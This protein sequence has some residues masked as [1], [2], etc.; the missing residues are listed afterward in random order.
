MHPLRIG[1]V[2]VGNISGIYLKNLSAT[3]ETEVVACADLDLDRAQTVATEYGVPNVLSVDALLAHPD[4]DLVLNLTIPKVHGEVA[5]RA[6]AAGK[7]VY[8][9]KPLA[10]EFAVAKELVDAARSAGLLVGCAPDTFL[11]SGIQT[12][13]KA[14]DDGLIGAPLAAQAFMMGFG[15]EGW[16]PNPTFFYKP[17][18]GPMLDMGPYYITALVTLLGP[19]RR[20][21]G[22][23][24][25]SYATRTIG[26]G[27]QKGELITVETPTH[28]SGVMEMASGAVAAITTSFD[29]RHTKGLQPITIYGTEGTMLVPDPNNFSG[30]VL[31]R[32]TED[33]EW[34]VVPL[35][36]DYQE[37][38]RGVGIR[39]LALSRE[40]GRA[41]RASGDLALHVLETMLSFERASTEGRHIEIET[42]I[43]RPLAL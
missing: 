41:P 30:E 26:S 1:V 28:L 15:P 13:R 8:N 22:V 3:P 9:E 43:D 2:G 16:H 20:T 11:G 12:A 24:A 38:S 10:T 27:A 37:N 31:V 39:D 32:R 25:A 42:K 35:V 21:T 33:T 29:V 4:V 7:H 5:L 36:P 14:I 34:T 23:T 17:G 40:E 19:V 18:G 6:I